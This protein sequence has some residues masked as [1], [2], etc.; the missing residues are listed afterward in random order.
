[1]PFDCMPV[2]ENP[3]SSG[4]G[5]SSALALVSN[6]KV[7]NLWPTAARHR[8][9]G[10][11]SID[12][13]IAVLNRARM[14]IA[15]ERHWCRGA[16]ARSWANIPMWPHSF[17]ARRFCAVGALKRAAGELLLP[18]QNAYLAL[19]AQAGRRVEGWNDEPTRTHSEVLALFDAAI[20]GLRLVYA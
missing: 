19:E 2:I 9:R 7:D 4:A 13:T 15:D 3:K 5:D 6:P 16:F 11:E 1:M 10:G 12:S 14:L 8:S 17:F 20:H 18:T